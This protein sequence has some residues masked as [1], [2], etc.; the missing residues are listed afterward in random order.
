MEKKVL[1]CDCCKKRVK[2]YNCDICGC[3]ICEQCKSRSRITYDNLLLAELNLC[4]KC[5]ALTY[6]LT[7]KELFIKSIPSVFKDEM[8]KV[9]RN[10]L[11]LLGLEDNKND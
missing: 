1:I 3:D 9:L 6:S 4:G 11:V 5:N 2:D 7:M 10:N 8:I